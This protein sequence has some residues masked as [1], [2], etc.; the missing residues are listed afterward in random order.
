MKYADWQKCFE[1]W[2]TFWMELSNDHTRPV[3]LQLVSVSNIWPALQSGWAQPAGQVQFHSPILLLHVPLLWH[4]LLAHSSISVLKKNVLNA[5]SFKICPQ[6]L[7]FH[8][9]M[10]ILRM[11]YIKNKAVGW[12]CV[13]FCA[14][15]SLFA[16]A[17]IITNVF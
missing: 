12:T 2:V 4:G 11:V 8:L 5:W 14:I 10:Y 16:N 7:F 6:K 3:I 9:A 15:V 1:F 13:A 17:L